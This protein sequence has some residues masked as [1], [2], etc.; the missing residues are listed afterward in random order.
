MPAVRQQTACYQH[1]A[2]GTS[3]ESKDA[4][5]MESKDDTAM[6]LKDATAMESKNATAMEAK[7]ATA[8]E[9]HSGPSDS[10]STAATGRVRVGEPMARDDSRSGGPW[11]LL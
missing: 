10:Q 11:C 4:T 1:A 8:M 3:M 2:H 7:D 6:E 5:A 9:S